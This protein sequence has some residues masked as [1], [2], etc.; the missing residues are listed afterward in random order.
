[1]LNKF[2]FLALSAAFLII[3]AIVLQVNENLNPE[4]N[5]IQ[6]DLLDSVDESGS[7]NVAFLT[8]LHI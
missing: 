1:M 8:D 7:I 2:E 6:I 4:M 5:R 3:I